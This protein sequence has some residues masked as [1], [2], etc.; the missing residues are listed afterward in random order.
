M[1]NLQLPCGTCDHMSKTCSSNCAALH[2]FLRWTDNNRACVRAQARE[3]HVSTDFLD[4]VIKQNPDLPPWE[5]VSQIT[6]EY[7]TIDLSCLKERDA[8][9]F[10]DRYIRDMSIFE[11]AEK[12]GITEPGIKS[13]IKR[14]RRYIKMNLLEKLVKQAYPERLLPK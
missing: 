12:Y 4:V 6:N 3:A 1:D 5:D 8:E 7:G 9:L 11:L 2:E 14:I 13:R 10:E